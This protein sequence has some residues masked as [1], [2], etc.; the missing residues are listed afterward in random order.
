MKRTTIFLACILGF[1]ESSMCQDILY[2]DNFTNGLSN[3]TLES[4]SDSAVLKTENNTLEIISP[5]GLTLWYNQP[6][7]A[8]LRITY[9]V[10][11]IKDN[12]RYDRVSDL[13]CFWMAND[14]ENPDNFFARAKWRNGTFGRY[15]SLTQYYVGYGGNSNSTTRFRKYDGDFQSFKNKTMRPDII[16]EYTDSSHLIIPNKWN[17]IEIVVR[18][19]NIKYVF[20]GEL[21]FDFNDTNPYLKG[22]FGFRTVT[23]HMKIKNF[24]VEK[25]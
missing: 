4:E 2:S 9:D 13:N 11:V 6:L 7:E 20:N 5:K 14:P 23:N 8:N 17:T 19:S 25:L 10:M 3:W 16:K 22:H 12:G 18:N 15:Y 24:K 1:I 21:L